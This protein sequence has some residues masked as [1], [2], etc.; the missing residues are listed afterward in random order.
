MVVRSRLRAHGSGAQEGRP[1]SAPF[2]PGRMAAAVRGDRS[3]HG[4]G[5][6]VPTSPWA[7]PNRLRHLAAAADDANESPPPAPPPGGPRLSTCWGPSAGAVAAGGDWGRP[8]LVCGRSWCQT[9]VGDQGQSRPSARNRLTGPIA[10]RS[11]GRAPSGS[12]SNWPDSGGRE[13]AAGRIMTAPCEGGVLAVVR[14]RSEPPPPVSHRTRTGRAYRA[15]R[16]LERRQALGGPVSH[17]MGYSLR[18]EGTRHELDLGGLLSK[19]RSRRVLSLT[20]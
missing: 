8:G 5:S 19:V 3:C 1:S 18:P 16:E 13:R 4:M 6:V 9:G 12:G 14:G 15:D 20:S 7:D 17:G 11:A 10:R 2:R